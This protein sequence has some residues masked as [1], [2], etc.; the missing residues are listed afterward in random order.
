MIDLDKIPTRKD[1]LHEVAELLRGGPDNIRGRRWQAVHG[2]FEDEEELHISG[3]DVRVCTSSVIDKVWFAVK[4][5]Q[6]PTPEFGVTQ[7]QLYA[8]TKR[9]KEES[10]LSLPESYDVVRF[11]VEALGFKV[12]P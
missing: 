10:V 3:L 6:K 5:K 11:I 7:A 2:V 1:I 8:I 4:L 12:T 9:L